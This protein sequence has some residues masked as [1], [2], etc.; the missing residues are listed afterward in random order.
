MHH[1]REP[2]ET[3]VQCRRCKEPTCEFDMVCRD[4]T[5]ALATPPCAARYFPFDLDTQRVHVP[6]FR[7]APTDVMAELLTALDPQ[8]PTRP[9]AGTLRREP[10]GSGRP[11]RAFALTAGYLAC[12]CSGVAAAIDACGLVVS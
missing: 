8:E 11:I 2:R 10:R 1:S 12:V 9:A 4:C 3:S 6:E 7:L 5:I